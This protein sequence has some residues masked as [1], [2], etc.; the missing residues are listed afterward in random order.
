MRYVS[1]RKLFRPLKE[2]L[3]RKR[4]RA[5]SAMTVW[6]RP[7]GVS[8]NEWAPHAARNVYR[9]GHHAIRRAEQFQIMLSFVQ[10]RR[11]SSLC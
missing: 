10:Q 2:T 5:L 8:G 7:V 3:A 4:L 6:R 9:N 11:M 1:R